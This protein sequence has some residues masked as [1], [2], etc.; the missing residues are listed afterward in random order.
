MVFSYPVAN[1]LQGGGQAVEIVQQTLTERQPL[2]R[3]RGRGSLQQRAAI[4]G[5][6]RTRADAAKGLLFNS[7]VT[8]LSSM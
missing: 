6:K 5:L 3:R 1:L 7:R 4:E 2:D 8:N